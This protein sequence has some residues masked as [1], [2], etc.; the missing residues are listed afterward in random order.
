MASQ[1][2][3]PR[4]P[5]DG[6]YYDILELSQ[7]AKKDEIKDA[8]RRLAKKYHP[9]RNVEDPEAEARFKEV[10]EAHATLSDDWKRALYDQDIQFSKFGTAVSQQVDREKWTEHWEKEPT[11]GI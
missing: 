2:R 6:R 10:Q 11:T 9:D 5:H 1:L 3:Q 4:Q 8:Y 7:K